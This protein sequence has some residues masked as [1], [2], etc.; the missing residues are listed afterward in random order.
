MTKT[1]EKGNSGEREG[2]ECWWSWEVLQC[3]YRDIASVHDSSKIDGQPV[4]LL[5]KVHGP[6]QKL[7]AKFDTKKKNLVFILK[8]FPDIDSFRQFTVSEKSLSSTNCSQN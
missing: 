1:S 7:L 4:H 6:I 5:E 2:Q 3:C 8:K